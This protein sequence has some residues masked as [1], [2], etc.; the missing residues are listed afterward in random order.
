V[1]APNITLPGAVQA[2]LPAGLAIVTKTD[3]LS[4][5]ETAWNAAGVT[6]PRISDTLT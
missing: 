2:T 4:E 5:I 3:P 6:E 1:S